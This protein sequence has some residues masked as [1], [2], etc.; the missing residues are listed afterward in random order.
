[1]VIVLWLAACSQPA[2][3][4]P[5]MTRTVQP[6]LAFT[7]TVT[8]PNTPSPT[9]TSSPS[10]SATST[11][12]QTATS[13]PTL[14]PLAMFSTRLLRPGVQPAAYLAESCSY[15]RLRWADGSS[16]PGTVVVP[17][18]FHSIVESGTQVEDPKDITGEQFLA[19]VE[20]A[21]RLGFE[22]ISSRQL[23]AFLESNAS[24][25]PRS[26]MIIVDDRR[27]GLIRE[28]LMPVLEEYDWTVTSA[29]IADPNSLTW[30]WNLME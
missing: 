4:A 13:T 25:P 6:S 19:F 23:L 28:W 5:T 27:P 7:P 16:Q 17:I 8:P 1:M 12:T 9:H 30:A 24:I 26:M 22:T 14:A 15:L 10:P 20:Y 21:H 11:Q 3:P 29:Y 2:L 18:M